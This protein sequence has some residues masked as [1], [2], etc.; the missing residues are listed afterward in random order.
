MADVDSL[1]RVLLYHRLNIG[2]LVVC[3]PAIQAFKALHAEA[4]IGLVCNDF[5]GVVARRIPDLEE[6]WTYRKFGHEA[7]SELAAISAARRWKPDMTIALSTTP[8]VKLAYRLALLPNGHGV[9][10]GGLLD[11][12]AYRLRRVRTQDIPGG[13]MVVRMAALFGL[14]AGTPMPYVRLEE[15]A[16]TTRRYSVLVHVD[17]RKP[18]DR[19]SPEQV[20]GVVHALLATT[21][22][23]KIA[24]TGVSRDSVHAGH[25]RNVN[26]W[27]HIAGKLR[28]EARCEFPAAPIADMPDLVAASD[29]VICAHG[30]VMHVAAGLGRPV[31]ALFGNVSPSVW[32]PWSARSKALQTPSRVAADISV[33]DIVQAW[34]SLANIAR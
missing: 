16:E 1:M 28:G 30:G 32:G 3:T 15:T 20:V 34:R 24:I 19:P 7:P 29:S 26:L 25:Q 27:D 17:A 6:L 22:I 31:V 33:D 13:H 21:G 4:R 10:S 2:D 14:P 11:R 5:A 18:S 9:A 12:L 23:G 8:D